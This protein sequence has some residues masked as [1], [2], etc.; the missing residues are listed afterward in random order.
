MDISKIIILIFHDHQYPEKNGS[1]FIL[2]DGLWNPGA[3][4]TGSGY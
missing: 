2:T 3:W 4:L 1:R